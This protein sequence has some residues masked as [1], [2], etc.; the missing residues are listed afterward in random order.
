MFQKGPGEGFGA[1]KDEALA[2]DPTL[3]CRNVTH[4]VG[5]PYF[6]VVRGEKR[7]GEGGRIARDAWR[8]AVD[9]LHEEMAE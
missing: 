3:R 1:A 7:V 4:A 6:V 8:A 2:L 9:R 5:R